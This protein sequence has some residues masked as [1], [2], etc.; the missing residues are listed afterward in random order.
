MDITTLLIIVVCHS[1]A[2]R[3][4]LVPPGTLVRQVIESRVNAGFARI[5]RLESF[6]SDRKIA[7]AL[8]AGYDVRRERDSMRR[9]EFITLVAG[10]M[11]DRISAIPCGARS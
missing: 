4:R 2:W 9:R 11:M 1:F 3:R 7:W 5:M 6:S 8:L 10:A